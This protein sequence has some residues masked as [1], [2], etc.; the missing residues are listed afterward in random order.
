MKIITLLIALLFSVEL[1]AQDTELDQ[2]YEGYTKALSTIPDLFQKWLDK[3][4]NIAAS[5]DKSKFID[6]CK[7]INGNINKLKLSKVGLL[8]I[9][10]NDPIPASFDS[11]LKEC[12]NVV[13]DLQQS[14]NKCE[15]LAKSLLGV[16][17]QNSIYSLELDFLYKSSLLNKNMTGKSKEDMVIL[18]KNL[19][20]GIDILNNSNKTLAKV[21]ELK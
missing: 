6:A 8:L 11:Q 14:L 5:Q 15:P 20:Q 17:P 1:L 4:Q 18:K 13:H 21:I 3:I 19:N 16:E 12:I 9:L 2:R 7:E 10:E